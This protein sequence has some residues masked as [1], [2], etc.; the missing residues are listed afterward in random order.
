MHASVG[1]PS[2]WVLRWCALVPNGAHVLDLACGAGRHARLFA[3]RGARVTAVDRDA[4]VLAGLAGIR[5]VRTLQADL[6]AAPWPFDAETFDAIV[7]TNY[8][9]RPLLPEIVVA[10]APGGVLLYETFMVGNERFGRPS[11][12]SF[13]LAPGELLTVAGALA[14]LG[15]EQGEVQRPQPAVVQRLCALRGDPARQRIDL[16]PQPV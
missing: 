8:L 1:I 3:A 10:L 11:N 9:H 6:E 16:E 14:V 4:E 7:V 5:G 2:P 12:P 15:F 13:L